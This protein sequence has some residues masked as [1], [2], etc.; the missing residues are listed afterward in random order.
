LVWIESG[1]SIQTNIDLG[2]EFGFGYS[3]QKEKSFL[4]SRS[5]Q[6]LAKAW[7]TEKYRHKRG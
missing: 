5:Y 6:L 2:H 1:D 4:E 7:M 3:F